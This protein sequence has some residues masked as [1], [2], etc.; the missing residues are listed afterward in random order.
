MKVL[1]VDDETIMLRALTRAF[2]SRGHNVTWAGT[3]GEGLD[4]WLK[5]EP[6]IVL[7]DVIMPELTGPQV[8][9]EY[10]KA[11]GKE[12]RAK[13]IL[14]TAHSSVSSHKEALS[15]GAN[16]FVKKPFE[17]VF[18]LVQQAEKMVAGK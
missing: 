17:N 4:L 2:E 18:E 6:D 16:E 1:I 12:P 3:G 10:R 8:I 7:I 14:M 9:E 15:L 13:I 5:S 11:T